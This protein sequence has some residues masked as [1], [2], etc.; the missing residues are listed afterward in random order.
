[1]KRCFVI[2]PI[3][4][5]E[6]YEVHLNRYENIIKPAVEGVYRD[7]AQ[8]YHCIRADFISR[9]GSI[10]R[11]VLEALYSSDAV[12]ADLSELNPNVF[13]EL[14]VRHSL[15]NK[16]VLIAEKGT[17]PPFDIGDLRIIFY[18]DK[19][20]AEKKVIPEIQEML[21]AF[22]DDES[23]VDSPVFLAVPSLA[24]DRNI[25]EVKAQFYALE[26]E[27]QSLKIKLSVA[28]QTNISLRDSVSAITQGIDQ[29]MSKLGEGQKRV[30]EEE[31]ES[32]VRERQQIIAKPKIFKVP[33]SDV[34]KKK[35]F[36]LMPFAPRFNEVYEVIKRA[37][38]RVG[39]V[40]FRV[41]E[42]Y[43]AESIMDQIF[44]SVV[45][46]GLIIADLTGR[47]SNVLYEI[48]IATTLGKEMILLSQSMDDVPFDI[49]HMRLIIY[50]HSLKGARELEEKLV[51]NFS[52]YLETVDS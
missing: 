45:S 8:I 13:Y 16:T 3:G 10:T 52:F 36:V 43:F 5:G 21:S 4:S 25:E 7:E 22:L 27:N 1:M 14:G 47:N 33:K 44:E 2:M 34:D 41:D 31:I 51:Y 29:I 50:E 37:A 19:V 46:S 11:T 6:R 9:T 40:C 42:L 39:L 17:K 18:E 48:G 28:E 35:V 23:M 32:I 15:R 38:N 49:R 20:G 24:S 30:T 12:I 26:Q